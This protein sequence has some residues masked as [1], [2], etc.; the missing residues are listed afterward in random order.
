MSDWRAAV[1]RRLDDLDVPPLRRIEIVEELATDAQDRYDE[2]LSAG[3][4]GTEARRLALAEIDSRQLARELARIEPRVAIDLPPLGTRRSTFMANVW[5]DL[6][7]AARSMRKTP[8]FSAIVIATLALGIGAN[9]AIFSVVDA[10]MVRPYGYPDMDRIVLMNERGRSG[11]MSV[12]WLNYQDW[13]VQQQ[14]FE[15]FGLYR[16]TTVN[17]TGGYE[18]ER[19]IGALASSGVFG[20][21]G[22][23]PVQGRAFGAAEDQPGA[24]NV[25]VISE[26]LWRARLGADPAILGRALMLNGEPHTVVGVMPPA[27]RFP[28]RLTDVWLPIGPAIRSFP[29]GRGSHPNLYVVAK[30]KAHVT[31]D[32]ATA[33]MDAIAVRLEKEYPASNLG[34]R[35]AMIPYYEAIVRFI[36]PTLFVLLG[37]VGFVL[38]I[39][40]ANLANLL[41]ARSEQRQRDLAVRRALG[42]DRWRI[43]QQLLTE[44]VLL[45]VV[46]GGLGLLLAV[47]MVKLFVASQPATIP[48][49]DLVGVDGRVLAFAAS[50]SM[51]TGILFGLV[52]ALRASSP[53]L[54]SALS[55]SARGSALAPSRRLRSTLVVV[56]VAL[57]LTLLV[58][59]GLMIRSFTKLMSI[60]TG[61]DAERVVTMRMTL[62][63]AKYGELPAWI[64]F[65]ENLVQRVAAVPGVTA[66]GLN[67]AIPLG[68]GGSE[69]GVV[70]EG[71]PTPGPGDQ[72][73]VC[74]FQA[75]TN[76]YLRAMGIPL[77]KGR[78]FN[79]HDTAS[80]AKVAIID[81]T[82]VSRLFPGEDPIGK[83]IAFEFRGDQNTPDPIWREV[84]G[85]V[86]HVRH[87][88]VA[89]GPPFVQVYTPLAQLPIWYE[90][91]RPAMALVA[92]TAIAPETLTASVRREVA[93]IDPD[94][95]LFGVQTMERYLAQNTE[96]PRLSVL[97]LGGLGALALVLAVIGIYGVVSYSV[98]QRTQEIG[99]R[100]A[101]GATRRDVMRLVVGQAMAPVI[102]G[103]TLGVGA[104]LALASLVRSM[105]F[106]VS[107]RD[108]STFVVVAV[109]LAAVGLVASI[110]PALRA[111]RVDPIV[112]LRES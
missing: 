38:L 99:V 81:E 1:N 60:E 86:R 84:V 49:I 95:P 104:A 21:L 50:L 15:H 30:R 75:S 92:R 46:G 29:T 70:V 102:V 91:R 105:L 32:A 90:Q 40:C 37:A 109:A 23:H 67:S 80:G 6:K 68:G 107:E 12:S 9:A 27:M 24:Q 106:Q 54:R 76:D 13:V 11:D 41:L 61:F 112:A 28:S 71:R 43:V 77:V 103:V 65:H 59:A 20:A 31:F 19:L 97:M 18:P 17:L 26:R 101:L 16:N 45:A 87:Y 39:G 55:Q 33:D 64:A 36:R 88:G 93:A 34:L 35:V 82:F 73:T 100:V 7:H 14:S 66:V 10:V 4:T 48:R 47:W 69:S 98:A 96:Q 74:L 44:S 52:P 42:A 56:E 94:I 53:D 72:R 22:V 58:G 63:P 8:S 62:P 110:V 5:Q 2:L 83:R 89:T 51:V 78:S 3:H 85:V 111:T 108:P 25:V 57:A 79:E